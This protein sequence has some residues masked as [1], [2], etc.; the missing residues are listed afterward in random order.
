[1]LFPTLLPLLALLPI[2]LSAPAPAPAPSLEK[3]YTSV[4]IYSSRRPSLCLSTDFI[5]GPRPGIGVTLVD[6][7]T[8]ILWDISP[9]AGVVR[10]TGNDLVLDASY[11]PGNGGLLTVEQQQQGKMSQNWY[12]TDDAR[13][14]ITGGNQCLDDSGS[15]LQ[16]WQCTTGNTNQIF[17][18][19]AP[20]STSSPGS[21]NPTLPPDIPYSTI[22]T[23]P[24]TR[25][26]LHALGRSD[27]CVSV[28]GGQARAGAAVGVTYC[29]PNSDSRVSLQL[30]D[31]YSTYSRSGGR[32]Y[33]ASDRNYCLST[34]DGNGGG[35]TL[36]RCDQARDWTYNAQN[37]R[38]FVSGTTTCLDVRAESR[39][40]NESP[41]SSFRILQSWLCYDNSPNQ[42]FYVLPN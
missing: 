17:Y 15:G 33:L 38:W 40:G 25:D 2:T 30:F 18:T 34:P 24:D 29:V 9:G 39:A 22:Y 28:L 21:N 4:L 5:R 42:S 20:T 23:D 41:L 32:I 3:R 8:A 12:L 10:V 14:A 13:I 11:N 19:R 31:L 6:C 27:L 1:M 16:T 36:Q 7:S 35:T 26:R 37:Q